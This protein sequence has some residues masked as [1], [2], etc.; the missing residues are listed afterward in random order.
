MLLHLLLDLC[1]I[2]L[3]HSFSQGR[4]QLDKDSLPHSVKWFSAPTIFRLL[5]LRIRVFRE[6][7]LP[8]T[9][10]KL[11]VDAT[12]VVKRD[13]TPTDALIRALVPISPL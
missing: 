11:I 9:R 4:R 8:K 1:S 2:L 13:I 5:L 3:S 12:T 10:S 6:P 7:K